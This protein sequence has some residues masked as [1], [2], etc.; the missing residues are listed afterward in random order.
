MQYID[1]SELFYGEQLV[2]NNFTA[3][4]AA[5]KSM[6]STLSNSGEMVSTSYKQEASGSEILKSETLPGEGPD[7]GGKIEVIGIG[8]ALGGGVGAG[9]ILQAGPVAGGA[10]IATLSAAGAGL[11]GAAIAGWE[12]GTLVGSIPAV[13]AWVDYAT[14]VHLDRAN[15][16]EGMEKFYKQGEFPDGKWKFDP[17]PLKPEKD[18]W[19]YVPELGDRIA[20]NG[21]TAYD[22]PAEALEHALSD[23]NGDAGG[24][25]IIAILGIYHD[26]ARGALFFAQ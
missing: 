13:K 17:G 10:Q 1:M 20:G 5:I 21:D 26:A 25:D 4:A 9:L 22:N 18:V 23:Y 19:W 7:G 8:A 15:V 12:F 14:E 2:D 16:P 24:G 11:A 6:G 3:S